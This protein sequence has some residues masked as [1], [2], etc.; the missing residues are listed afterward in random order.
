MSDGAAKKAMKEALLFIPNFIKL[1]YRLLN[2]ERVTKTDRIL[3]AA[4]VAYLLS[5]W[6]FVPDMIPFFG[7][8]DD[9]LLVALVLKRLM[10]SVDQ[11]VL[12]EY[13]DGNKDLI[14]VIEQIID[15]AVR[16]L[17][18]GVYNKLVKKSKASIQQ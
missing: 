16:F 7:Q 13:W 3:L 10:D 2:D 14:L 9:V 1:I 8:V 5:P 6:D 12:L 11:N 4:T 18:P 17:P 15:L